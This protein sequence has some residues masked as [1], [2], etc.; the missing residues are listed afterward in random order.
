MLK[1][2]LMLLLVAALVV[3]PISGCAAGEK[4]AGE[5]P[6]TLVIGTPSAGSAVFYVLGTTFAPIIEKYSGITTT[7][8]PAGGSTV[9]LPL[10]KKG[11]ID[12]ALLNSM[13]AGYAYSGT[14]VLSQLGPQPVRLLMAGNTSYYAPQARKGSGIK[15]V[16]DFKGK[17]VN[18]NAPYS[19][20]T[21]LIATTMLEVYGLTPQDTDWVVI[22]QMDQ[23]PAI[24]EGRV[25]VEI[26][27][28]G[29][30]FQDMQREGAYIVVIDEEHLR[31]IANKVP[32]TFPAVMPKGLYDL[33]ENTPALGY[34]ATMIAREGLSEEAAYRVVKAILDHPEDIKGAHVAAQQWVLANAL[35]ILPL[36]MHAGAVRYYREKGVWTTE[37][38]ARQQELL[39]M[40]R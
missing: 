21:T 17:R 7:V 35:K 18:G 39:K 38:E 9:V 8:E 33:P 3:V 20:I 14:G 40:S 4:P 34:I 26:F 13:E 1:H 24:K 2:W 15:T 28:V 32:G 16:A 19:P 5:L 29:V 27:P 37:L 11:E 6:S 31:Q 23:V 25:D 22:E 36:P 30:S 12:L 10:M